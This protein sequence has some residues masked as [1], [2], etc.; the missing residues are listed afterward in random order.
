MS[1][2]LRARRLSAAVLTS[3]AL[4]LWAAAPVPAVWAAEEPAVAVAPATIAAVEAVPAVEPA[5]AKPTVEIL[6]PGETPAAVAVEPPPSP[7]PVVTAAPVVVAPVT[8]AVEL[9]VR[10]RLTKPLPGVDKAD[11]AALVAFYAARTE[12]PVWVKDGQLTAPAKTVIATLAKA[13]D[14][15]ARSKGVYDAR[16]GSWCGY[17]R[18]CDG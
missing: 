12:G 16:A 3:S 17:S 18:A 14:W 13:A 10:E 8:D 1:F 2:E 5:V 9:A 6:A 15:G 4:A 7:A 11:T